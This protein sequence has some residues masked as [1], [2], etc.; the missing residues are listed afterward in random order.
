MSFKSLNYYILRKI[1]GL[2]PPDQIT[3]YNWVL[4]DEFKNNKCIRLGFNVHGN[5]YVIVNSQK[6]LFLSNYELEKCYSIYLVFKLN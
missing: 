4:V 5:S 1:F 6:D 2:F 3:F